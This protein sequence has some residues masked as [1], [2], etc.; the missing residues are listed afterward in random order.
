MDITYRLRRLALIILALAVIAA[1]VWYF[2]QGTMYG[3]PYRATALPADVIPEAWTSEEIKIRTNEVMLFSDAL[4]IEIYAGQIGHLPADTEEL[5]KGE[6]DFRKDLF[7]GLSPRYRVL[8]D[9]R[10]FDFRF[11]GPD[12]V[13]D[14]ADDVVFDRTRFADSK[15]PFYGGTTAVK[16]VSVLEADRDYILK[17]IA[18][19]GTR[20]KAAASVALAAEDQLHSG[21]SAGA[22]E[23]FNRAWLLDPANE[24]VLKG[25]AEI[26]ALKK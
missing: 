13:F 7:S 23:G 24:E 5:D 19:F 11:A 17:M 6:F 21:N 20:K 2:G 8:P 22:M 1:A 18:Q 16:I 3:S 14:T 10:D 4:R 15:K 26:E 9:G 25:F 12:A